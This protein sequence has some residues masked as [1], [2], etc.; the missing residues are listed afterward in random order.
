M[1]RYW[2][3]N[4]RSWY[5]KQILKQLNEDVNIDAVDVKLH[6]TI[7]KPLHVQWV[8]D[9]YNEMTTVR[10]KHIIESGWRAAE[11]TDAIHLDSKNYPVID[12]FHDI[13]ALLDGNIAESQQLQAICGLT[14]AEK[15]IGYS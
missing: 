1:P 11:I 2:K 4:L 3:S 10:G 15:Q 7:L 6:L 14:L 12:P 9:F 5:G 8:V 13:D